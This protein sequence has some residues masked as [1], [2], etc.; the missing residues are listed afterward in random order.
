MPGWAAALLVA[1]GWTAIAAVAA[2]VLLRPRAQPS[3]REE[4]FGLLQL[5]AKKRQLDE[6]QT[7]R[8]QA[9]DEAEGEVR[10]TSGA[11]VKALLDEAAEHQLKALPAVAKREVGRAEGDAA[12]LVSGTLALLTAPARAGLNA[13][14]RFIETAPEPRSSRPARDS[15]AKS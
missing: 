11:L 14:S 8:E 12:E 7:S 13:L 2:A 4:L 15:S 10:T 3:E 6:L 1:A 9:R 5:L